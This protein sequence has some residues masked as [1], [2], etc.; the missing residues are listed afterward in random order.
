MLAH[1]MDRS[2]L[3]SCQLHGR[4]FI[5]SLHAVQYFMSCIWCSLIFFKFSQEQWISVK[6]FGSRSWPT[7]SWSWSY[8]CYQQTSN[9]ATSRGSFIHWL[10]P[11]LHNN[12]LWRLWNIMYLKILWKMEHLR[13]K[14]KRSV[15]KKIFKSIQNL[16]EIFLEFF[17]VDY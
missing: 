15:F 1:K 9:V 16:T 12:A 6:Q 17:N 4:T 2:I 7:F 13:Q 11:L 10:N 14:S 5:F 8:K 3:I